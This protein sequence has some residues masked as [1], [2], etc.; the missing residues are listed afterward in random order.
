VRIGVPYFA[1]TDFSSCLKELKR[2]FEYL[3][4]DA[5]FAANHKA[6]ALGHVIDGAVLVMSSS[7]VA[8]DLAFKACERLRATDVKLLGMVLDDSKASLLD[9]LRN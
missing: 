3:L 8:P 2:Y 5:T 9:Q 4:I 7:G 1:S 6:S